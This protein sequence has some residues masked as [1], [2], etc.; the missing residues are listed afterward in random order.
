MP[1][2]R[3][4]QVQGTP[5]LSL[6][7]L[8]NPQNSKG[9]TVALRSVEMARWTQLEEGS[10]VSLPGLDQG[11][12]DGTVALRMED[13]GWLRLGGVL[14]NAE[15][16]FSLHVQNGQVGGNILLP[17]KGIGLEL[18]TEPTGEVLLV[19]RR[20]SQ[21]L[22]WPSLP[23][24]AAAEGDGTIATTGTAEIPQINT[25]P[26]SKGLI[27]LHFSGG[28][29]T[30]PDWNGGRPI[31]AA[32]SNLN[33]EGIREV[34]ARVAEDYAPFDIAISTIARDYDNAAAGKRIR[35]IITPTNQLQTG[36]GG[37]SLIGSWRS[38]G[39]IRSS[40]VPAWVFNST[41]KTVAEAASHEVGHTLGLSHDGTMNPAY[42]DERGTYHPAVVTSAYYSGT[43]PESSATGWAPIMGNSY[44]RSLTQ[45]SKGEYPNASNTEDD[46]A[47]I[48][49][50]WNGVG[51]G[52][53][54]PGIPLPSS[55]TF[56]ALT[57]GAGTFS[58]NGVL[59]R[60][61]SPDRYQ[62]TTMGGSWS[63][64]AKPVSPKFTNVDLQLELLKQV[65]ESEQGV[66]VAK[67]DPAELLESVLTVPDLEAG[68][69]QIAVR[70]AGSAET[71]AGVYASGYSSYGSLGPY[72]LN[73]FLESM[74][75][76]PSI[77]SPVMAQ[78]IV[79]VTL[80]LPITLSKGAQVVDLSTPLPPGLGWDFATR[81]IRGTPSQEGR[82]NVVFTLESN[83]GKLSQTLP[84]F[85]DQPGV[86]LPTVD[87]ALG[88]YSNSATAPWK[89]QFVQSPDGTVLR[90]LMSGRI[91]SGGSSKLRV[92]IPG[93]RTVSFW[94]KTSS[95]AGHDGLECRVNGVLARDPDSG[96]VLKLSGETSWVRQKVRIELTS[97]SSLEFAYT[98]DN[99]LSEG[100]DRG[101]VA[102]VEV[103]V[104]PLFRKTPVSARLKASD[105]TLTL[106]AV[107]ENAHSFQWK[108]DGIPLV[109][110]SLEGHEIS[111]ATTQT[112]SIQGIQG[113]DS[114]GYT[115]EA[116]N[117]FDTIASRRIDVVVPVAPVIL[118]RT[119]P[120]APLKNGETL[121]LGVEAAGATP[122]ITSWKKDGRLIRRIS[123][124]TL[125]MGNA[126]PTMAGTY[127]V[128][129][130]NSFG[131]SAARE[132]PVTVTPAK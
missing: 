45:W 42:S 116:K 112:L 59:R 35:V 11:T 69:Y 38:S 52:A 49:S 6:P 92:K 114:G 120:V 100:E 106:A 129:V 72:Q 93:K 83:G 4:G 50:D 91:A 19:E 128:S 71:S 85:V 107:V 9:R 117:D 54:T 87:G 32:P 51:Y 123:G 89:G 24:I 61:E 74:D 80:N 44:T 125:K 82:Y 103:G 122:F 113:A 77:L 115:L 105:K 20:I 121:L 111:G 90:A 73:G 67:A 56:G 132:I 47:V 40:T 108:K 58:A 109:D 48:A 102:N 3:S 79:G 33:A 37:L 131:T 63:I 68:T 62:F 127:S 10:T 101:W 98:K 26:G 70:S 36:A 14:K 97:P 5:V 104:Q 16:T 55:T 66:L 18:R 7:A 34:V 15:G 25:R 126:T 118:Q 53:D 84:L 31:E 30:D 41:P 75:S 78:A 23:E 60:T 43:G 124:T 96:K 27:Y 119:S 57:V 65:P 76:P 64:T 110:G 81:S 130:S 29:I 94:W 1:L 99:T 17:A 46:L 8:L 12:Y 21:I 28:T 13:N 2:S 86:P 39:K 88:A 95:E 22:C